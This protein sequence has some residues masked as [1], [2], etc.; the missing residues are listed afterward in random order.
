MTSP[1]CN[2]HIH[3]SIWKD[4]KHSPVMKSPRECVYPSCSYIP[5]PLLPLSYRFSHFNTMCSCGEPWRTRK[6]CVESTAYYPITVGSQFLWPS[7]FLLAA[8]ILLGTMKT[9]PALAVRVALRVS[10]FKAL[11]S[12]LPHTCYPKRVY[13]TSKVTFWFFMLYKIPLL[14]SEDENVIH[15]SYLHSGFSMSHYRHV[16]SGN[17]LIMM[18]YLVYYSKLGCFL[19]STH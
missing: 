10:G 4:F 16:R 13:T 6:D 5:A 18:H 17:S 8:G 2:L 12:P 14:V 1:S 9:I 15:F 11:T 19:T 7:P 3:A